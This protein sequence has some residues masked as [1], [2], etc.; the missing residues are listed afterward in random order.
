MLAQVA[1]RCGNIP[2]AVGQESEQLVTV[3]DVPADCRLVG[4]STFKGPFQ[5]KVP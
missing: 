5:P 4:Q 3:G 2:G 1:H